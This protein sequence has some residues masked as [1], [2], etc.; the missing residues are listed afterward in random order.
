MAEWTRCGS[1]Q[2]HSEGCIVIAVEI[3]K[4][5]YVFKVEGVD[6]LLSG[7]ALSVEAKVLKGGC[8]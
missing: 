2:L 6:K 5:A 3:N 8:V 4:V 1:A 7:T